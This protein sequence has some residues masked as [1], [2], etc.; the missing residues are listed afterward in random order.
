MDG[1]TTTPTTPPARALLPRLPPSGVSAFKEAQGG[2]R[3]QTGQEQP[4]VANAMSPVGAFRPAPFKRLVVDV[5][6]GDFRR[7]T[8]LQTRP[9]FTTP[10]KLV[11]L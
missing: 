8:G 4:P 3:W 2:L 5:P 10:G 1:R 11:C 9:R 6:E 7:N